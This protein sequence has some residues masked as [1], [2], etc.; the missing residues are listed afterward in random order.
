MTAEVERESREKF[1]YERL[2]IL[3]GKHHVGLPYFDKWSWILLA[4]TVAVALSSGGLGSA[5][6]LVAMSVGASYAWPW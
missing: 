3:R 4:P 5:A 1:D 6:E 2:R